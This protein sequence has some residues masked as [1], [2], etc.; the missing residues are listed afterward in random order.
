MNFKQ[1]LKLTEESREKADSFRTTGE[2]LNKER[3]KSKVS[4][5]DDKAKDAARKR[6]ERA[7][8]V[9]NSRKSKAELVKDMVIVKTKS[10]SVQI[11][12]KDSYDKSN[13]DLLSKGE[14][15]NFEEAKKVST[16]PK[17]EQTTASKLLLGNVK[18]KEESKDSKK[19]KQEEPKKESKGKEKETEKAS[20]KKSEEQ[21]EEPRKLNKQEMFNAM[22]QMSPEQLAM[23]PTEVRDDYFKKLRNPPTNS[24]FDNT[25]FEGLSVK[26][27]LSPISSLPFNQQVLNALLFLTKLKVGASEQEMQTFA[28]MNPGASEFTKRAY[29]QATKILSQIGDE[30]LNNLLSASDMGQRQIY[31]EGSVDMQCGEYKFKIEAGGEFTVSTD[32]LNQSNKLFKGLLSSALTKVFSDPKFTANEPGLKKVIEKLELNKQEKSKF[33][34]SQ[35]ALQSVLQDEKIVNELKQTPV[36]LNN[37]TQAG[38]V[39]DDN[40]N[41]NPAVNMDSWIESIEKEGKTI[42]KKDMDTEKSP[43]GSTLVSVVLGSYLRGD[44]MKKQNEQPTHVVTA[45]GIFQLTDQYLQEI[46]KNAVLN[47][48][49]T[50]N[51]IDSE[52]I[53]NYK[54]TSIQSLKAWRA[55]IEEKQKTPSLKELMTDINKINPMEIITNYLLTNMDF[56]INA[57]L[58]P[59]F[60]PKDLNAVEYNY[61]RIGKKVTKIPV[62]RSD[63]L[64]SQLRE[65]TYLFLNDLLVESLTNNFVLQNLVKVNLLSSEEAN[66]ILNEVLMESKN[67]FDYKELLQKMIIRASKLPIKV[68]L[69][70]QLI[71]EKYKRD[72]KMEYRNYHGKPKQRKERAKRTKAREQLEKKGVVKK[73]DGKDI[74]HKNPLRSGGSNSR[75]NL[76]V[77]DRSNNRADNGHKKGEKQNKDWK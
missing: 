14:S 36:V 10:G 61:V 41:I 42:F 29:L 46:S 6:A 55:L 64:S 33:L 31:K 18:Q 44:G 7:K 27:G 13:H 40:N 70:E 21:E 52:N 25:T 15:I 12:F 74:D 63:R 3:E 1:L 2:A 16:D 73:G 47:V 23:L 30:C 56:E 51:P 72:Y 53:D 24:D 77:R 19:E 54:K 62:E 57:S 35:Q 50:E 9:P 66:S 5:G 60:K 69:M 68:A 59:G 37:G 43:V 75:S 67:N 8:K 39:L 4:S 32:K 38:F 34:I 45:N 76:R 48:K 17:F 71:Y 49:P 26:F 58:I 22:Q 20:E 28:S 65:D 11:I